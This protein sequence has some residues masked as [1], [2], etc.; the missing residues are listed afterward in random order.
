MIGIARATATAVEALGWRVGNAGEN[1]VALA[2]HFA[3]FRPWSVQQQYRLGRYRLDFAL[4]GRRIAI[5]ADGWVH[6]NAP[7]AE[8]DAL[9][10]AELAAMGWRTIRVDVDQPEDALRAFVAEALQ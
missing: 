2:L 8:R 3:G 4:V 6:R 9:R 7:N 5:E 1:R 10:D